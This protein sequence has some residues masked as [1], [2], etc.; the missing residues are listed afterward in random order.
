[1]M[2]ERKHKD[3]NNITPD[4]KG[5]DMWFKYDIRNIFANECLDQVW[6]DKSDQDSSHGMDTIGV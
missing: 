4:S 1:M 3:I 2:N 5:P 6:P